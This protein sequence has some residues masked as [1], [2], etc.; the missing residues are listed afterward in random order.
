[1]RDFFRFEYLN[2]EYPLV[3][4]AAENGIPAAV[5]GVSDPQKYL[6]ASM[7]AGRAVYITADALTAKRAAESI[8]YFSGKQVALLAAKDEVLTFR[9]AGSREALFRRLTALWQWQRGAEVLVCD[10]EA[11]CQLV[12]KKLTVFQ[13]EAGGETDM[14]ALIGALTEAGY[15]R[16]AAPESKGMFAV[17]LGII[18]SM[19]I[20]RGASEFGWNFMRLPTVI[21][22]SMTIKDLAPIM[23]LAMMD[24]FYGWKIFAANSSM[25][26]YAHTLAGSGLNERL[27]FSESISQ[28]LRLCARLVRTTLGDPIYWATAI[29]N[30]SIPRI[31]S[32]FNRVSGYVSK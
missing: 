27:L 2:G 25:Q 11:L 31:L 14:R 13:L 29:G 18:D 8:S 9:R 5:F 21:N 24:S 1:M 30:S 26:E 17:P 28:R 4:A 16:D 20:T 19:T 6:I 7:F 15:V 12:P 32:I 23:H 3:G 10:I 22:V